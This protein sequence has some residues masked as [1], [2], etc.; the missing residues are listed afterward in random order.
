[1]TQSLETTMKRSL[2]LAMTALSTGLM[3]VLAQGGYL[4]QQA[5]EVQQGMQNGALNQGQAV[6]IDQQIGAVKQQVQA[7]RAAQGGNLTPFQQQ[8]LQNQMHTI[9][10]VMRN[11]SRQNGVNPQALYQNNGFAPGSHHFHHWQNQYGNPYNQYPQQNVYQNG[12]YPVQ[13]GYGYQNGYAQ[14]QYYPNGYPQ[15]GA[16]YAQQQ[17]GGLSGAGQLLKRLF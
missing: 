17:Q 12:G 8:T 15:Q 11:D 2:F 4:N 9:G 3:P 7:E 10:S 16:I 6:Q 14:N 13:N 5:W 1:M